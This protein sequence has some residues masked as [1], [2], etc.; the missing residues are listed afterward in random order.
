MAVKKTPRIGLTGGIGSGKSTVATMLADLGARVVDADAI[1][2][3]VTAPSGAGLAD[4]AAAFGP[5]MLDAATGLNRAAMRELVFKQPEAR[6]QLEAVLRPHILAAMAAALQ[7]AEAQKPAAIVLDIPLLVENL[8][9]WRPQIDS[10]WVVDC[11]AETQ[12]ARVLTRPSSAGWSR[13]QVEG[14][15]VAQATRAARQAAADVILHNDAAT[16][17]A[18]LQAQVHA[19]WQQFQSQ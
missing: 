13:S 16:S 18:Q 6:A 1:A 5:Q 2:R 9:Q 12:I 7:E 19:A 8:A 14:V 15:L 10:L 11:S 17:M 4:V 3:S